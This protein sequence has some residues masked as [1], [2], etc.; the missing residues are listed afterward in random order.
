MRGRSCAGAGGALTVPVQGDHHMLKSKRAIAVALAALGLTAAA[1]LPT[2]LQTAP[3][4]LGETEEPALVELNTEPFE[5]EAPF[6]GEAAEEDVSLPQLVS[7]VTDYGAV[8]LDEEMR[9][10]ASAVYN[11]ARGEPIEGQLAVAQ[12][13]LN[14]AAD[15]RWPDTICGVVYQRYQFSFTFDGKPD[16]PS[17]TASTWRR[18][19]AVAIIAA[20]ENWDDLTENA[21]YYHATY[22]SPNWRTAFKRT[23]NIG[24]HI[25]YR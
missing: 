7:T 3:V 18:A 17:P 15:T 16:F 22:V 8:E 9:C 12:V 6:A 5:F 24:R 11:E 19:E 23:A 1:D 4:S 21:V 14:R 25:F 13:V 20:T 10:L 2:D